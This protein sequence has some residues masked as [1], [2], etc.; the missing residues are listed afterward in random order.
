MSDVSVSLLYRHHSVSKFEQ[1]AVLQHPGQRCMYASGLQAWL[2]EPARPSP[3]DA[4]SS[5]VHDHSACTVGSGL[6]SRHILSAVL[7][8]LPT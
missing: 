5:R 4:Q 7:H 2:A 8:I 6:S 1:A 3:A